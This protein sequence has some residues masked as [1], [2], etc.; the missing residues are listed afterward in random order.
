M[1][2]EPAPSPEEIFWRNVGLPAK[3]KRTGGLLSMLATSCLCFFWSIPSAFLSSLTEVNSLKEKLPF[4]EKWI[5]A[6]PTIETLLALIAPLLLLVLNELVL[7]FILKVRQLVVVY[8]A[9][10]LDLE[11]SHFTARF[12]LEV[13]R[14]MGGPRLFCGVRSITVRQTLRICGKS[15][16]SIAQRRTNLIL[17]KCIST[18]PSLSCLTKEEK[19]PLSRLSKP[20]LFLQFPGRLRLN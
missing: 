10:E 15:A 2:V 6:A 17:I 7:P 19:T 14:N 1:S 13:V 9:M 11:S 20:S 8:L 12:I 3:A 5:E 16:Q 4:L 18:T